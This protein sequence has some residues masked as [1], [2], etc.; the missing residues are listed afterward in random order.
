MFAQAPSKGT[1]F[2]KHVRAGKNFKFSNPYTFM[3]QSKLVVE[4]AFPGDV[5][6]LYD[7]GNF[8]IGDTLTDGKEF[9][10]KGIPSFSPELFR[11]VQNQDPM[12]T[13]QLEKGLLQL[14][15]EGV[16]QLFIRQPGNV[17]ILGTVGD[18]QFEVIQYRLKHEY[19]AS[20]NFKGLPFHKAT[21]ITTDNQEQL[22]DFLRIKSRNIVQ[23]KDDNWVFLAESPFLLDMA[24]RDY[25]DLV[26]HTTSEFK[27]TA[28]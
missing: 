22:N 7:T 21:W 13:K 19:G 9:M 27:V 15:E 23:D 11:E 18:L 17:K 16:A 6:G 25:P 24:R 14:T 28:E 3:A 5:V 12:K 26:F 10:F 4:E 8:K 1:R 2:Y 20:C